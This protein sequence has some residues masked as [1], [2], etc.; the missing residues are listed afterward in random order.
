MISNLKSKIEELSDL[1]QPG[2]TSDSSTHRAEVLKCVDE[3][4]ALLNKGEIR[5]AEKIDGKWITYQWIKKAIL[6]AFKFKESIK[7]ELDSFDKLGLLEFDYTAPRYRKVCPA[8]IRDGVYIGN[9]TV[10]MP[11]YINTGAYIGNGTMIDINAAI[12]SCAQIGYDCHISAQSCIGGVLEPVVDNPVIIDD[13]CF[14]GVHSSVLEGV[15][16]EEDS[17]IAAGVNITA[18]TKIIDRATGEV[19]LGRI[20]R[21]SVVVSGSYPSNGL[22]IACCIIVKTIDSKTM[23]K[24]K[25]NEILR[26]CTY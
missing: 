4:F 20:P 5:V 14:I 3:V 12:G 10:I 6:L 25:I 23:S 15:I 26:G 19:R 9:D 18:S 1:L 16:V 2:N 8:V 13:N 21:G 7:R 22:N 11:S 24:V 17:I